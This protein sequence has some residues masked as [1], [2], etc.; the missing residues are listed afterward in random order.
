MVRIIEKVT[1]F[2]T[3]KTKEGH[4]LLLIDHPHA[5]T[6]IPAGT[7]EALETPEQ[8]VLRETVEETGL[9]ISSKP[10]YL[11]YQ[12]T[13]LPE[14]EAVIRPPA[15]VYAR[16]DIT[17]FDWIKIQSAVQVKVLRKAPGF[18][19]ISYTEPDQLPDP[20][21]VSMQI[22]GWIPDGFLAQ[23]RIRHFF[24]LEFEGVTELQWQQFSDHHTF[25]VFWAPWENLPGIIPPQDAW[26]NYLAKFFEEKKRVR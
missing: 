14:G 20:N 16:P 18:T 7:V 6:Q 5:G 10:E 23:V 26:L 9:A 2:I 17:S 25:T 22:T 4:Q 24:Y 1:A 3:R 21:Y 11:G 19:Q 12:E 13:Q 15:T 8:A